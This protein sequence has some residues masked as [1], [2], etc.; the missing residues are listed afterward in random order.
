VGPR[1]GLDAEVRG[2]NFSASVR[3]GTPIILSVV[4]T[5]LAELPGSNSD[6][7]H[8]KTILLITTGVNTI[9]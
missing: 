4:K 6:K 9:S 7:L 3:D 8:S 5:I 1:A 2:K